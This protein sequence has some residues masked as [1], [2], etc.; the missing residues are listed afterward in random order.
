MDKKNQTAINEADITSLAVLT[1]S[2]YIKLCVS[3][4][5]DI[6]D[7]LR[8]NHKGMYDPGYRDSITV[9][10]EDKKQ[11]NYLLKKILSITKDMAYYTEIIC[12]ADDQD[13]KMVKATTTVY[14]APLSFAHNTG[15]LCVTARNED[16]AKQLLLQLISIE[17][18]AL[19]LKLTSKDGE[20]I[21]KE[22]KI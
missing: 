10:C 6:L 7:W 13:P 2:D 16:E 15:P 9:F 4:Q 17:G 8:I 11:R 14:A 19:L 20:V 1:S 21:P 22:F 3:Q 18:R 12:A 5:P